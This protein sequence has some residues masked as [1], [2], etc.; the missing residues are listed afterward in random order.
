MT[1]KKYN[2]TEYNKAWQKK[3]KERAN[4]LNGRSRSRGFI[5]KQATTEDLIELRDMIDERL[6]ELE[7]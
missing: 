4:Y 2:Q 5:R 1:D 7:K 6:K 3:N